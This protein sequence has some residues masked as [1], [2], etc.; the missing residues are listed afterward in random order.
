MVIY[1]NDNGIVGRGQSA[2]QARECA[3]ETEKRINHQSTLRAELD[4]WTREQTILDTQVARNL[5]EL[6]HSGLLIA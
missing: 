1:I 4:W 3:E 5:G 6:I 2:Q